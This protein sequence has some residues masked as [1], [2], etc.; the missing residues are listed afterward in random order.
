M[1][2]PIGSGDDRI[3]HSPGFKSICYLTLTCPP[4]GRRV[5]N[6]DFGIWH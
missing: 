3:H 1:T 5:W 2:K 4:S 6:L